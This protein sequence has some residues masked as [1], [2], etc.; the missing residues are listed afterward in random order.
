[1]GDVPLV[2]Y[3]TLSEN[4]EGENGGDVERFGLMGVLK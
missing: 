1:M 2:S 4:E 3:K